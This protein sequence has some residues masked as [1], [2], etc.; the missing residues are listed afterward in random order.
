MQ[1]NTLFSLGIW[2][3]ALAAAS[4]SCSSTTEQAPG[5]GF[6]TTGGTGTGGASGNTGK[7]GGTTGGTTSGGTTSGGTTSGG[8]T[9]GGTGSV[10]VINTD[11]SDDQSNNVDPD[12]ACGTGE[13][14]A[15]LKEVNMLVMFDRSWSMTQCGDGTPYTG[16]DPRCMTGPSRWALTSEALKQFFADPGADGLRV[17]LRFFPDDNPV[18][19][20]N[21]LSSQGGFMMGGIPMGMG[22]MPGTAGAPAAGPTCDIDACAAPLV[23]IAALTADPAPTDTQEDKLIAAVNTSAPPDVAELNPNPLTPTS[24]ALGGAAKW[25]TTYAMAHP[26]EKVV[27]VLVTDGEPQGC[28]MNNTNIARIASDAY[29]AADVSTY[30]IGLT[31]SSETSLD[32]I[33]RAGGTEE[34]FTVADGDTATAD[35]LQKLIDIRGKA[36]TC[37]FDVPTQDSSGG[38]IDPKLINVNY[39]S[40]EMGMVTEFGNVENADACGAALGWYY[41]N[42]TTPTHI[43][44]CPASCEQVT[45]DKMARIQ[46]LAGCVP[47]IIPK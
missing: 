35:L 28:D 37:D 6:V 40:G 22:G 5:L 44:L 23:D 43:Y 30:V 20:C 24:A 47:K 4:Y 42:N 36:L 1:K 31:G 46:V 15:T 3:G 33:A 8:T 38:Q 21:G 19:G 29:A 39:Q 9:S 18:V 7:G 11:A 45:I 16:T 2:I 26:D 41:D 14:S 10:P 25:A 13:A 34:A 17:A 27:I 12:A 32:Q